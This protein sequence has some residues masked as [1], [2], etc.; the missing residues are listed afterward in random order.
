MAE[1]RLG[2][3]LAALVLDGLRRALGLPPSYPGDFTDTPEVA[4][5]PRPDGRPDPGEVVWAHVPFEEDHRRGKDRPVLLIG[6]DGRWL[7]GL[8]LTSQ[9]RRPDPGRKAPRTPRW[10]EIGTGPW[11]RSQRPSTV[12]VDRIIRVHPRT[13]RREGAVLDRARFE[14][15]A[16]AV[17]AA[18]RTPSASR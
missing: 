17:R 2:G 1:K 3:R 8:M 15:V 7:L 4:Y 14:Q 12:R 16:A 9:N 10:V 18:H 6:H 13:V 11:D 5:S